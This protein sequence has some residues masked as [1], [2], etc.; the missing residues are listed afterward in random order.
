MSGLFVLKIN[1]FSG[2]A[3]K[4]Q[5]KSP[6]YQ[7]DITVLYRIIVQ[8]FR[9]FVQFDSDIWICLVHV[10]QSRLFTQSRIEQ[11]QNDALQCLNGY[12]AR[13]TLL[14]GLCKRNSLYFN[15]DHIGHLRSGSEEFIGRSVFCNGEQSKLSLS[16]SALRLIPSLLLKMAESARHSISKFCFSISSFA[17]V[18]FGP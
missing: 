11:L 4:D 12:F 17:C 9:Y 3:K 18:I 15:V 7:Y 8:T 10:A 13:Y 1:F 14:D 6:L 16:L 2:E 5:E